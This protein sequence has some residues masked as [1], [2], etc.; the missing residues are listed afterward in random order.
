MGLWSAQR[1]RAATVTSGGSGYITTPAVSILGG[2]GTNA[3]AVAHMMNGVVTGIT[4]TGAGIGYTNTPQIRIEQP[5][6]AALYP[7]VSPVVRLDSSALAPYDKYQIE[8]KPAVDTAW[9][10][11]DGGLFIPTAATNSQRL[12][13]TNRTGFFRLRYAE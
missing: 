13:I 8:F 9:G 4:I 3:T 11:W 2:G 6:S 1:S 7:S 12:F 5:P 10:E